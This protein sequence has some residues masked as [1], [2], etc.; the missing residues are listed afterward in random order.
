MRIVFFGNERLASGITLQSTPVLSRLIADQTVVAVVSH[1]S[2]SQSR[3][4][5]ALEVAEAAKDHNI[6]LFLPEKPTE[7]IDELRALQPDIGVL[8]AYG[9]IIPQSIIDIFPHGIINLHPSLLP[10]YRGPTPIEQAILN[11]DNQTGVS[12]MLLTREMDAGP[13]YHQTK[14]ELTGHET[15]QQLV[16]HLLATG[17][18]IIGKLLPDIEH[19]L[20]QSHP[21]D[22]TKATYCSL[23][24]KN[25]SLLQPETKTATQLEREIRAFAGWP[26]SRITIDGHQ[27]IVTKAHVTSDN[28][29]PLTLGCFDDTFLAIDELITP[30]GKQTTGEAFKNGYLR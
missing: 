2:N 5:R 13:I 15:K 24:T 18:E 29:A 10:L 8:V 16:E 27:I 28:S 25:D 26:K 20:V 6:P 4:A 14:Q 7:I 21:Q 17:A 9:K 30:N 19:D 3:T 22:D 1:Y 23:L 11:G 12:I